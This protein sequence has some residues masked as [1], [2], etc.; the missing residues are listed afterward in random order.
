MSRRLPI[1]PAI[2]LKDGRCVRLRQ[3]RADDATVYS[4]DPVSMVRRWSDGGAEWIHVVDLDGAFRGRP[5]HTELI[6]RMASAVSVPI[7]VGGGLRT[8]D[9]LRATLDAGAARVIVGTRVCSNPAE[10][11]RLVQLFGHRLAAGLDAR[12]GIVQ[13]HGWTEG[14]GLRLLDVA[15]D[16][17]A[18]GVATL[19]VTDISRDGMLKGVNV[20]VLR[21]VCAAVRCGVIASGG[22]TTTDDVTALRALD[23]ANL[24]GAIVGKALYEGTVTLE[25][26]IAAGGPP[27]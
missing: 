8:D 27:A 1:L 17:D 2:D 10:A 15:R 7:E 13:V 16:L 25:A 6:A 21:D 4:D 11:R 26:M 3:G 5:A 18:A 9:D 14:G 20:P 19:I 12:D 22:V 24:V 23:A